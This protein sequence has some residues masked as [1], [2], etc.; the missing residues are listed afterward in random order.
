MDGWMDGWMDGLARDGWMHG[1]IGWTDGWMDGVHD[2]RLCFV[3]RANKGLPPLLCRR[4]FSFLVCLGVFGSERV[5]VEITYS[6]HS[7]FTHPK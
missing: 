5:A 7:P 1:W 3:G 4:D 2:W 6:P